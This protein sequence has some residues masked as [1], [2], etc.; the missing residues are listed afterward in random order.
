M[1]DFE[2]LKQEVAKKGFGTTFYGTINGGM[3]YLSRGVLLH[4]FGDDDIQ[5]VI[6]AVTRFQNGDFGDAAAHGKPGKAGHEYGRY[7]V[8]G[9][10]SA[11]NEDTAIWVHRAEDA[12]IVYFSFER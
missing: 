5:T 2:K 4:F 9:L 6:G 11:E 10:I 1:Q 12:L 8:S 3:V 7:E